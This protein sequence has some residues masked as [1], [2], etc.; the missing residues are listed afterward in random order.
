[1]ANALQ[2]MANAP[3]KKSKYT[4]LSNNRAL[5]LFCFFFFRLLLLKDLIEE[6]LI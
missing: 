1:M 4:M 6:I 3:E 2:K 5:L